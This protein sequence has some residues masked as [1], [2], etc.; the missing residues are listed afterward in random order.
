MQTGHDETT[1]ISITDFYD[2]NRRPNGRRFLF[3]AILRHLRT[4][5]I[6]LSGLH[7]SQFIKHLTHGLP[8]H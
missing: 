2:V 8:R 6:A 4:F 1:E 5:H 3:V 7:N